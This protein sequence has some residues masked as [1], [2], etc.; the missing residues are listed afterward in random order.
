L[1]TRLRFGELSA[2][3]NLALPLP[4]AAAPEQPG[5]KPQAILRLE[6]GQFTL[7]SSAKATDQL[8]VATLWFEYPACRVAPAWKRRRPCC[9]ANATA[10]RLR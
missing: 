10:A 1:L 9:A 7:A 6:S 8:A 4:E 2:K 5:G 3:R